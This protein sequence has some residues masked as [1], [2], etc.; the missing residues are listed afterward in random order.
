MW[1]HHYST[2]LRSID[3][4]DTNIHRQS[5]KAALNSIPYDSDVMFS[6]HDVITS[7]KSLKVG[8]ASGPDGLSSEHFKFANVKVSVLLLLFFTCTLSHGHLPTQFMKSTII[9][10]I[11]NKSGDITDINNYRPIALASLC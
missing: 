5:V 7:I 10:I 3:Q 2:L 8:K 6:T 11:K 4:R 1:R 9:P